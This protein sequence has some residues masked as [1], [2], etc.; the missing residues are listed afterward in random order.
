MKKLLVGFISLLCLLSVA[1][2]LGA[3]STPPEGPSDGG[4]TPTTYT[5]CFMVGG[6]EYKTLTTDESGKIT[7]PASPS[8][9]DGYTFDGWYLDEAYNT[10]FTADAVISA[11]TTVYAKV[12]KILYTVKFMVGGEE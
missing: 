1:L 11:N 8:V 3:C 5:V 6:E 2:T 12:S 10:E 9:A 7:M 4:D